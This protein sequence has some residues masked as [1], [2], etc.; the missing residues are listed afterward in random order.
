[1]AKVKIYGMPISSFTRTARLICHE[2]GVDYQFMPILPGPE[3][4]PTQGKAAVLCETFVSIACDYI[5]KDLVVG[6]L[7]PRFGF[8]EAPE[9]EVAAA[10]EKVKGHFA[11]LDRHLADNRFLAGDSLSLADL[12]LVPPFFHVRKIEELHAVAADNWPNLIRWA[13]TMGQRASVKATDPD[14]TAPAEKAA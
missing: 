13:K 9:S 11:M 7:I 14:L 6:V 2:K 5:Y 8:R 10:I 3:L 12:Y 1:M 4:I